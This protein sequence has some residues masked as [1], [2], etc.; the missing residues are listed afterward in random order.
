MKKLRIKATLTNGQ[1]CVWEFTE[2][3]I[4]NDYGNG[5]YILIDEL[6]GCEDNYCIDARYMYN[7]DF[8]KVCANEIKAFYGENLSEYEII[9]NPQILAAK[10]LAKR[11]NEHYPHAWFIRNTVNKE[12]KKFVDEIEEKEN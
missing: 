8:E 10:E 9:I 3:K 1:E 12:L 6:D 4:E 7:Y 11:I 5:I 2:H